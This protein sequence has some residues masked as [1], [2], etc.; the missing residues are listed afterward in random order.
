MAVGSLL[1]GLWLLIPGASMDPRIAPVYRYLMALGLPEEFWGLLFAAT[2]VLRLY[3]VLAKRHQ[4]RRASALIGVWQWGLFAV[5][6]LA[7]QPLALLPTFVLTLAIGSAISY[8]AGA[9]CEVV[10]GR[11]NGT[12]EHLIASLVAQ[13]HV[14]EHT[15][16][17]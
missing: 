16:P 8:L 17:G 14:R 12:L 10:A 6:L 9:T 15:G 11:C 4:I 7:A 1:A 2:G 5:M 3:S 13:D